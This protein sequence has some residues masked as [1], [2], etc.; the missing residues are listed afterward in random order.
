MANIVPRSRALSTR[1][2]FDIS[3]PE[4]FRDFFRPARWDFEPAF[5]VRIDVKE[6]DKA[7][8]VRAEIPGVKKEDIDVSIDG[9]VITLRAEIKREKEEKRG[10][11]GTQRALL[12]HGVAHVHARFGRR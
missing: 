6:T 5:D 10:E 9:N 4:F 7:Y 12:R 1:D 2:P 8:R 3:F 11:D